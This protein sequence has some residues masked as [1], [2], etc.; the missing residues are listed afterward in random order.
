MHCK[1]SHSKN[2]MPITRIT[3]TTC[4]IEAKKAERVGLIC[5]IIQSFA[6]VSF[7]PIIQNFCSGPLNPIFNMFAMV[8]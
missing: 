4:I 8:K 2:I 3:V 1:L 7:Y 6:T 5:P